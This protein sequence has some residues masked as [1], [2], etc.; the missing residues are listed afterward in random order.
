MDIVGVPRVGRPTKPLAFSVYGFLRSGARDDRLGYNG[1]PLDGLTQGYFLGNGKR[2]YS[3][4][5]MRFCSPDVYSPFDKGGLNAYAYCAGDPV[6]FND[7]EGT[8]RLKIKLPPPLEKYSST[9]KKIYSKIDKKGY[10][11]DFFTWD[12]TQ[13]EGQRIQQFWSKVSNG[14]IQTYI[15]DNEPSSGFFYVN[16]KRT[17]FV[18]QYMSPVNGGARTALPYGKKLTKKG[19]TENYVNSPYFYSDGRQGADVIGVHDHRVFDHG[20]GITYEPGTAPVND[21]SG[22]S[23]VMSWIRGMFKR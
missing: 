12:G 13:P 5:L 11:I 19:F 3:P 21:K 10:S 20:T 22:F 2:L 14:K 18:N 17:L 1:Q 8:H 23:K 16:K 4:V 7:T 15:V 9:F 6:N